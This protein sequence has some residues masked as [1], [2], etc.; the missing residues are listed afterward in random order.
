MQKPFLMEL[1]ERWKNQPKEEVHLSE[2][3]K[4][5]VNKIV[6]EINESK[7]E[8]VYIIDSLPQ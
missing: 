3:E 7:D 4:E 5:I 6:A 2:A 8:P 1:Y